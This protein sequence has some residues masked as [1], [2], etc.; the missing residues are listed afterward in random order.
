MLPS[1]YAYLR[2]WM[3]HVGCTHQVRTSS[4]APHGQRT[5]TLAA[6]QSGRRRSLRWRCGRL[7]QGLAAGA[8]RSLHPLPRRSRPRPR[9]VSIPCSCR[10]SV[11]LSAAAIASRCSGSMTHW[12]K[13]L[14]MRLFMQVIS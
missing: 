8:R 5:A 13:D 6:I 9:L 3:T 11:C 14:L 4:G 2:L 7:L 1:V 12:F 10:V